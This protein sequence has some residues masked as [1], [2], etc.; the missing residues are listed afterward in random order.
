MSE[1]R[2]EAGEPG[3]FRL[4]G[5]L[6]FDTVPELLKE[7]ARLLASAAELRIDLSGVRRADSAGL[8]LLAEWLREAGQR[9]L[10]LRY[11]NVPA[12]LHNLARVSGLDQVLPFESAWPEAEEPTT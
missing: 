9:R 1:P 3:L 12:Q 8:A 4:S 2:L 5:E 11:L 6:T 10:T 7:G